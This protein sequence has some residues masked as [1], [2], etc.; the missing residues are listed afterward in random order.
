MLG[1]ATHEPYFTIIREEFKPNQPRPCELCGQYG[2]EMTDCVGAP[3][4]DFDKPPVMPPGA[5]VE[6]IF[7]KLTVLRQYLEQ[8]LRIQD[9]SFN[10]DLERVIDDWVFMCFFV[11][12][13]F[14]PHL[15]SLEIREG[16]IDRLISLYK[17]VVCDTG[18]W[19]TDSGHVHLDRVQ[20]IMTELGK[21]EDE[22]FKSRRQDD[23]SG[24]ERR[25]RQKVGGRQS[26]NAPTSGVLAPS[27]IGGSGEVRRM[28]SVSAADIHEARRQRQPNVKWV[29]QCLENQEAAVSLRAMLKSSVS[30][31]KRKK[32]EGDS[33]SAEGPLPKKRRKGILGGFDAAEV[34]P[35]TAEEDP[36]EKAD[37][38]DEVRLW[39]DGWRA[40]YYQSKFGVDPAD[41][42]E[43]C[44][45]GCASWD[46]YFPY[47]YAP[48]ASDFIDIA[49]VDI[50]F[51][52]KKTKPFCP[53]EQLMSVFPAASCSHV[54][55]AWQSLM[56]DPDSP[57][58]D[59]Y[60]TDF[61]VDL[62]GKRFAWMGVALL[63]FVDE[64]R[65]LKALDDRRSKL[66]DEERHRNSRRPAL[67]FAN[68][69]SEIGKTL[70]AI[71]SE[72]SDNVSSEVM[73]YSGDAPADAV[74]I[75]SGLT[76]GIS[77]HVWPV[78]GAS[79]AC[80][81][82]EKMPSGVPGLL[83][84]IPAAEQ[85]AIC[86]YYEN[87]PSPFGHV[88][89]ARLLDSVKLPPKGDLRPPCRGRGRGGF[90][91]GGNGS[92]SPSGWEC[93]RTSWRS[94]QTPMERMIRRSL[95]Q[96]QSP[97]RLGGYDN[98]HQQ[99]SYANYH[100][101]SSYPPVYPPPSEL[102]AN[103]YGSHLP[104]AGDV[105]GWNSRDGR[106]APRPYYRGNGSRGNHWS[107]RGHRGGGNDRSGEGGY[108]RR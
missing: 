7:I 32:S 97:I 100:Q 65:L 81:P 85:H 3:C 18:G 78:V 46:W 55:P 86:V 77:G 13:D 6:F 52:K 48:F 75:N 57:I 108:Y 89:P 72:Q 42:P 20:L 95:P 59:F 44:I 21:V 50:G 63:P 76:E 47:H 38:C 37:Q 14:L 30:G 51:F 15:P 36:E 84:D 33:D 19:L 106:G 98:S 53:L 90:R 12:N 8:E 35:S 74:I 10:W 104:Q 1:L 80:L 4:D 99:G 93:G 40:R 60:P 23:L 17:S 58:I 66:T 94:D 56:T 102:F 25:K 28:N 54:P 87:P 69:E 26:W 61:K 82:G 27:P 43:F 107:P 2:H 70:T 9:L 39:E 103:P 79:R 91:G 31:S 67:Y 101:Q 88:F 71:Y 83:P 5:D 11:G 49:K 24:R 41:A 45:K 62:N 92:P 16:A 96:H 68:A 34:Q 105:Y 73:N 22:I 64:V 29:E